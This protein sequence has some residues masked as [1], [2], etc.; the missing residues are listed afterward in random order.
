MVG[1]IIGPALG[2]RLRHGGVGEGEYASGQGFGKRM[3]MSGGGRKQAGDED[4]GVTGHEIEISW[5]DCRKEK[6]GNA[7]FGRTEAS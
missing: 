5:E 2:I 3:T 7:D 1:V 4:F 6:V